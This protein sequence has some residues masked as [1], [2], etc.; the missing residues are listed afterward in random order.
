[1]PPFWLA[2]GPFIWLKIMGLADFPNQ[3][4]PEHPRRFSQKENSDLGF[5]V[6]VQYRQLVTT[7][8]GL[9]IFHIAEIEVPI[10]SDPVLAQRAR[11]RPSPPIRSSQSV[12]QSLDLNYPKLADL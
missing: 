5:Q 2:A 3:A 9:K 11:P 7:L 12:R 4:Y 8:F 6:A 10:K 1:M